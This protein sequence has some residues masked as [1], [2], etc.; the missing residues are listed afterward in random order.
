M[1]IAAA[2][3]IP[4]L[5]GTGMLEPGYVSVHGGLIAEVGKGPP[6]GTPDLVLDS[7]VLVPGLV[8][9]QVNGY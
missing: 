5:P 2:R 4:G 7:G 1:L 9:L 8:D 6:P 3:V